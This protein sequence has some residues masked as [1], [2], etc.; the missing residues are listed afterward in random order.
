MDN[1][2]PLKSSFFRGPPISMELRNELTDEMRSGSGEL[3][4]M[5]YGDK[6]RYVPP[7]K[8]GIQFRKDTSNM[9]TSYRLVRQ[10]LTVKCTEYELKRVFSQTTTDGV[11]SFMSR[12]VG[13]HYS[14]SLLL[15]NILTP[16]EIQDESKLNLDQELSNPNLLVLH[17]E[18]AVK[19]V[20]QDLEKLRDLLN[21]MQMN[22]LCTVGSEGCQEIIVP[23]A[24]EEQ[25]FW[26]EC[27][28]AELKYTPKHAKF[29]FVR[30]LTA[31]VPQWCPEAQS[32]FK[33]PI[34]RHDGE[35]IT[36]KWGA[37]CPKI[38]SNNDICFVDH[39]TEMVMDD[40]NK[41][42]IGAWCFQSIEGSRVGCMSLKSSHNIART[43]VKR[44]GMFWQN[45]GVPGELEVVVSGNLKS[46]VAKS[47]MMNAAQ[48]LS[49]LER[50]V[51]DL[52]ITSQQFIRREHWV[53]DVDRTGC[54]LCMR[55]FRTWRRKHHC[56]MCGEVVCS[57]CSIVRL[58]EL[59]VVGQS[60]LRLCKACLSTAKNAP[61]NPNNNTGNQTVPLRTVRGF[62]ISKEGKLHDTAS[63]RSC[64]SRQFPDLFVDSASSSSKSQATRSEFYDNQQEVIREE[65]DMYSYRPSFHNDAEFLNLD[66]INHNE[67]STGT[68]MSDDHDIY[69]LLCELACQSLDC[70]MASVCLLN[71]RRQYMKETA[72]LDEP[73][74][75]AELHEFAENAM[76]DAALVV[77]DSKVD[78]RVMHLRA[79]SPNIRFFA[80][81]PVVSSDGYKQGYICVADIGKRD[82]LGR[83]SI[84][85]MEKLASLAVTAMEERNANVDTMRSNFNNALSKQQTSANAHADAP[86]S[87]NALSAAEEQMRTLLWKSYETQ[88]QIAH[89]DPRVKH[90]R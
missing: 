32:I 21:M 7:D 86:K 47:V 71:N 77:L 15:H 10:T 85:K 52:R 61:V 3:F 70:P 5:A 67:S 20:K 11:R 54:Q 42:K 31:K 81:C 44:F 56:R 17:F 16:V 13:K 72:N 78:H 65:C 87:N 89:S 58:V 63:T 88:Q 74:L 50:I 34:P 38:A 73:T 68:D 53:R 33:Q 37:Y 9:T 27:N 83:D 46:E 30:C 59:P 22:S 28:S 79:N 49:N 55:N 69:D 57:D 82:A 19:F 23:S 18:Q 60:K 76:D 62:S 90:L 40:V 2:F 64:D 84:V 80:G 45:T 75:K 29:M 12:F 6:W 36:V 4:K 66:S 24:D 14:D 1:M 41:S 26:D 35:L 51:E 25:A 8:D 48:A 39:V 43:S